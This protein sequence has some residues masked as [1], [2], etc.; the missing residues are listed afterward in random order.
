MRQLIQIP[1]DI[2]SAAF[3]MAAAVL[4]PGSEVLIRDV[5]INPTRTGILDVLK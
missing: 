2:S 3:I 5:G 4:V 1:G